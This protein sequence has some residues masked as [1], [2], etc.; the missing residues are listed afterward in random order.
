[1]TTSPRNVGPA[2]ALAWLTLGVTVGGRGQNI[3]ER[4]P[5]FRLSATK[6][7][8]FFPKETKNTA[9]SVPRQTSSSFAHR[10]T[11]VPRLEC[12]LLGWWTIFVTQNRLSWIVYCRRCRGTPRRPSQRIQRVTGSR[13]RKGGGGLLQVRGAGRCPQAERPQR[14]PPSKVPR[15]FEYPPAHQR[16]PQRIQGGT[17]VLISL[18][19]IGK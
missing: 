2:T 4:E 19:D 8:L 12:D 9:F 1:M 7:Q 16:V 10:H 15:S 18:W 14:A 11:G 6:G 13:A 5:T 3:K 17:R